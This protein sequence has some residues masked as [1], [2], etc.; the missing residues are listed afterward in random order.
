MVADPCVGQT[1]QAWDRPFNEEGMWLR[2]L[3]MGVPSLEVDLSR[4][5]ELLFV[6]CRQKRW[7]LCKRAGR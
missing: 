1:I 2:D 6:Q 4:K 7:N 3:E 5:G